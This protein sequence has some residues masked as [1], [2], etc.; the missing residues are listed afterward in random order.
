[1]EMIYKL[2]LLGVLIIFLVSSGFAVSNT[3]IDV[4]SANNY[5]EEVSKVIKESHYNTEVI[6]QCCE[7]AEKNGYKL[8]ALLEGNTKPG[9]LNYA[10]VLFTYKYEIELFGVSREKQKEKIL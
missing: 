10:K 5:F 1:M 9:V 3:C 6:E 2:L 8:V 7:E 4:V